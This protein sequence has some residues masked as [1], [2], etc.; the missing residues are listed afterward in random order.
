MKSY[1]IVKK[2]PIISFKNLNM[3]QIE[4]R[5]EKKEERENRKHGGLEAELGAAPMAAL[6]VVADGVV[7]AHADPVR[8]RP[9]L[10]LLLRQ[11]LLYHERFVR[12]LQITHTNSISSVL[13]SKL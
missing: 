2:V 6:G 11:L 9:V 12:R 1:I 3:I 10:P 4:I 8:D 13:K 5:R 7:G